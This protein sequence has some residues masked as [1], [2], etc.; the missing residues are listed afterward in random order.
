MSFRSPKR[1]LTRQRSG[2]TVSGTTTGGE[3]RLINS[4]TIYIDKNKITLLF[5]KEVTVVNSFKKDLGFVAM[6]GYIFPSKKI[7]ANIKINFTSSK[8]KVESEENFN[9]EQDQWNKFGIYNVFNLSTLKNKKGKLCASL[10]IESSKNIEKLDFFGFTLDSVNYYENK[11]LWLYFNQKTPIYLPEIFYF[12][13]QKPFVTKPH[14]YLNYKF[15]NGKC[16]ILKSCNRCARFLPVDI[17]KQENTLSFSR[18]C[19]S[20]APCT[21]PLFSSYKILENNCNS[22]M[23]N[24][25]IVTA[26]YGYQLECKSCKK[27]YVNA[28]LNPLRDSTQHREDSL[29]RRAFEVLLEKLLSRKSIYHD[30]KFHQKKGFDKYI[31]EKFD[32]KCF[33]CGNKLDNESKMDVDHTFPLAMLWPIDESA[34]CLCSTCNGSKSSKFPVDFYSILK[35]STLSK[36]TGISL[37]RLKSRPVNIKA[38]KEL[39]KNIVWFF[40][41]F[42]MKKDYQKIRKGKRTADNIYHSLLGVIKQSGYELDL[43]KEYKKIKQT[44]PK[45]ITID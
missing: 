5:S 12:N 44:K 15:S 27:F 34:T 7:S 20:R 29:R 45:S 30:P 38:L 23:K 28:P 36:I 41:E 14:D 2:N 43:I 37:S 35:L 13:S 9:W 40:D 18:H 19:V 39:K 10:T 1:R 25:K 22:V 24:S 32:K 21:H 16:I 4:E 31:F 42:L 11:D 8:F 3:C 6:G 26:H 17:D 33:K